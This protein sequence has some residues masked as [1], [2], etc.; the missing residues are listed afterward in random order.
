VVFSL[1]ADWKRKSNNFWLFNSTQ[2]GSSLS[3]AKTM[4]YGPSCYKT[5]IGNRRGHTAEVTAEKL[6]H[7]IEL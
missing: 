3:S 1:T 4:L 7:F 6:W 2:K 5:I